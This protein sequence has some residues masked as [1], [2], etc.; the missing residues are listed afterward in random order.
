MNTY[1]IEQLNNK[2]A[3]QSD[4]NN[5]CF[6]TGK[7]DMPVVEIQNK[8]ATALISLQGAHLLSWIPEGEEEVIWLSED[9][10][11][12]PGKSVRGG[13]PICWPWFG[14]HETNP[15]FPAHGFAR[16]T[17]W[18][19]VE[20]EAL[21]GGSTRISF[22]TQPQAGNDAMWPPETSVL[23]QLIIGKKLEMELVTSNNSSENITIGQA[24]HTY[25]KVGDVSKVLLHGLD[26][27]EYVDKLDNFKRKNQHGPVTI[28]EEVDR[29][30]L[31]TVTDCVIEDKELNRKI[32]IVKVGS[33][34]TVVWNP[35]QENA[36]KM[37]DLGEDGYKKM[38]CVESSNAADDVVTIEPGN[39][40]H[41][42]VQ[43]EVQACD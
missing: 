3:L 22:T 9:A 39:Q 34:S 43:Y 12:A 16:T 20:T 32:V 27:T 2:F 19:V 31:G 28:N 42:W 40:H 6:K 23:F 15:D 36:K 5:L 29:I 14:P 25:F 1:D 17:N 4:N 30:Y 24:L 38:L 8:Q 10:K 18:Q 11:F 35:W 41:F 21:A 26:D 7:G 13:I 37:G 33:H